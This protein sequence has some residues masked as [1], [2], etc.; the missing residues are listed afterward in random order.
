M[1]AILKGWWT[2]KNG[3]QTFFLV[4]QWR[5]Q[6]NSKT[7]QQMSSRAPLQ[8]HIEDVHQDIFSSLPFPAG[9]GK[10]PQER[11]EKR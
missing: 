1:S 10:R 6:C 5:G 11:Y 2:R 9:N 7:S 4:P 3:R 8:S